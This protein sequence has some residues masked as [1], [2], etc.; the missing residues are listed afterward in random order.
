MRKTLFVLGVLVLTLPL[1]AEDPPSSEPRPPLPPPPTINSISEIRR[2]LVE[3]L[4]TPE[5]DEVYFGDAEGR[6][7]RE[8]VVIVNQTKLS[9]EK[10][11]ENRIIIYLLTVY[12]STGECYGLC[13]P[14][15]PVPEGDPRF[16][17]HVIPIPPELI[18]ATLTGGVF[19]SQQKTAHM[20]SFLLFLNK[21][22]FLQL[23][24]ELG[25]KVNEFGLDFFDNCFHFRRKNNRW[26]REHNRCF[27][28][29][30]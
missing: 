28:W 13:K 1:Y 22:L 6:F 17:W 30:C 25:E 24:N 12:D 7:E 11:S 10:S 14:A 20:S 19:F 18:P 27:G 16:H 26:W 21:S 15:E 29:C 23:S 3:K 8:Q 2:P 9:I 5:E 4:K